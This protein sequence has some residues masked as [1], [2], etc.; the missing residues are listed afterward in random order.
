MTYNSAKHG[1]ISR[2]QRDNSR[3]EEYNAMLDASP[4]DRINI[5]GRS[6]TLVRKVAGYGVADKGAFI[7][8]KD[9][10]ALKARK[11][12]A[13]YEERVNRKETPRYKEIKRASENR[14][15]KRP[16]C[17]FQMPICSDRCG[18]RQRAF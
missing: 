16:R 6:I 3:A 9:A 15:R 8:R 4:G 13:R 14:T 5:D 1:G 11:H 10:E 18:R 2:R 17:A 7:A 12:R